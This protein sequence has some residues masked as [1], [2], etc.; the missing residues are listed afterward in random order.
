MS[1]WAALWLRLNEPIGAGRPRKPVQWRSLS[2]R[3]RYN[4]QLLVGER[5]VLFCV[6]DALLLA[7]GFYQALL[8]S[9]GIDDAYRMYVQL[10]VLPLLLLALPPLSSAVFVERRSGSLDLALSVRSTERYFVRR[11]LA[12]ASVFV[13]QGLVVMAVTPHPSLFA[14]LGAMTYA[15]V[16][17][18]LIASIVLFWAVRIRSAGGVYVASLGTALLLSRWLFADPFPP[19]FNSVTPGNLGR[20]LGLPAF[21]FE[22]LWTLFVLAATALVF[23]LYAQR[24]LRRPETIL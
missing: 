2:S 12:L 11:V 18:F 5:V 21:F 6:L 16:L 17:P 13:A 7:Y 4:L 20:L 19:R 10:V 23:Y 24:R 1:R 14:R 22:W 8:S 9:N 15:L 3:W